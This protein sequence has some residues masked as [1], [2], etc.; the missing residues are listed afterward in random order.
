MIR[1]T[2]RWKESEIIRVYINHKECQAVDEKGMTDELL[3]WIK[4]SRKKVDWYDPMVSAHNEWIDDLKPSIIMITDDSAKNVSF[5]F[6]QLDS[7]GARDNSWSSK[8]W[9]IKSQDLAANTV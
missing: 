7:M 5:S 1:D 8:A 6:N 2:G 9:Y 3:A 4:W